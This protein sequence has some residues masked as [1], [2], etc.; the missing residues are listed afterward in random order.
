MRTSS[1]RLKR[2]VGARGYG[3]TLI[4]LLVVIAIIALLIALLLPALSG[5]RAASRGTQC[6]SNLRQLGVAVWAYGA[7]FN[8]DV[9]PAVMARSSAPHGGVWWTESILPYTQN[10]QLLMCTETEPVEAQYGTLSVGSRTRAWFDGQQYPASTER[11]DTSGYG[12]NLWLNRYQGTVTAWGHAEEYHWGGTLD[13]PHASH[14][15]LF[16][17]CVW[18]GGYPYDFEVP[19][20]MEADGFLPG[21]INRFALR[22]HTNQTNLVFLDGSVRGIQMEELWHFRW[23]R[24]FEPFHGITMPW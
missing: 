14:V 3:F 17:D 21:E 23:S 15:P 16:G 19:Y 10:R 7:D 6:L 1:N 8:G 18:V 11:I 5:A 13:L 20:Q 9:V 4:E 12:Q 2:R 22:R 24:T